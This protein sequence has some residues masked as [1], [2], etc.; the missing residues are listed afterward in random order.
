M[1]DSQRIQAYKAYLDAFNRH[2][3]KEIESFLSPDCT[4]EKDGN[5]LSKNR[6]EML[7]NYT[8]HWERISSP[9]ELLDIGA[10]ESG[11]WVKLRSP[12]ENYDLEVDYYY[13]NEGMQ[14]KHVIKGVTKW[15]KVPGTNEELE[16]SEK[17][18]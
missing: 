15:D 8:S 7:P 5:I 10:I 2:S 13:N 4:A 12:D 6:E 11:V 1:D 18:P 9:I 3:L 14:V 16:I 17:S